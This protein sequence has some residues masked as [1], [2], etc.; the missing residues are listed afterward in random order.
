MSHFPEEDVSKVQS[1]CKGMSSHANEMIDREGMFPFV[2][3][4]RGNV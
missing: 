2:S 1:V 3:G 4:W